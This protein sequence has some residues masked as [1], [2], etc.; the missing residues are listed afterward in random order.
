MCVRWILRTTIAV[1]A[2]MGG[3]AHAEIK[4]AAADG[5][6][7]AY[8]A[9]LQATPAKAWAALVQ[10]GKW[11]DDEHTW[12]GKAANLSLK[13]TAG[14]CWCETWAAGSAEHGR[15]LMALP[16]RLLR[17]EAALG[18]LQEYALNGVLSLWLREDDYGK[19]RIELEYRVHGGSASA[20]DAFA[21]QVDD[22]LGAQFARLVRY[23]DTGDAAQPAKAEQVAADSARGAAARAAILEEWKQELERDAAA[24][25]AGAQAPAA[26]AAAQ[27]PRREDP[28]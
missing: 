25:K 16:G 10:V 7:L 23:I 24:R 28:R 4:L 9:P 21:P 14:G 15:V 12:S 26:P 8:T 22:V 2:C 1:A 18:P 17:I 13:P 3:A 20:L 11:W 6:W 27:P 19:A 5:F